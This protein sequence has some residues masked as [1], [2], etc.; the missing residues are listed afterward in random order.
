MYLESRGCKTHQSLPEF[1]IFGNF[2]EGVSLDGPR[3]H[4][5]KPVTD[6]NVQ[7]DI[8]ESFYKGGQNFFRLSRKPYLEQ[9]AQLRVIEQPAGRHLV[10][11]DNRLLPIG[12]MELALWEWGGETEHY[13]V[14]LHPGILGQDLV[15]LSLRNLGTPQDA[16]KVSD[17]H[18]IF[19]T[20]EM[21]WRFNGTDVL[22]IS[23]E[24]VSWN[25]GFIKELEDTAGKWQ[26]SHGSGYR[27]NFIHSP[28]NFEI[29]PPVHK[30]IFK[31]PGNMV[32]RRLIFGVNLASR[33]IRDLERPITRLVRQG[34]V[35]EEDIREWID[36]Y[37]RV[38]QAKEF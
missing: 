13:H 10:D 2:L 31:L 21:I 19:G 7:P 3:P 1:R 37:V 17:V 6:V 5:V 15:S 23:D 25:T 9:N 24:R 34:H 27:F 11:A 4:F 12:G 18:F 32:D 36:P 28:I 16:Q 33:N 20:E 22:S 30:K 35:Q 38:V 26:W 14:L 8:R 29:M